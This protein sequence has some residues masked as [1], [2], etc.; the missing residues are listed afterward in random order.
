[1]KV[2]TYNLHKGVGRR[3]RRIVAEI[4]QALAERRPDVL[5][6]QEVF[7]S[8]EDEIKQSHFL[9]EVVGHPHVFA[10][11]CFR[12]TGCHGNA[13]F[14]NF[15]IRKHENIDVSDR[16]LQKRGI[17]RVWLENERRPLEVLNVHFSLTGG[18]RR[19]QWLRMMQ[20]LPHDP[21]TPVIVCGDFNDWHGALDRLARRSFALENALWHLPSPHRRTYPSHRPLF[22]LDRVYFR[23]LKVAA[24]NVL[25]GPPWSELSDHLPVEVI[26][27]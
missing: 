17:L 1:M 18:Q 3:N 25:R 16:F 14:A 22:A 10:P 8:I 23:G 7:H 11:N 4:G 12:E 9:T 20:A 6:C 24:V 13:T 21:K 5:L 2:I 27:E 15:R 19:R 26:F